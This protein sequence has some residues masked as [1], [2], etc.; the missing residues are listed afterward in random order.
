M[1]KIIEERKKF[2]LTK[3]EKEQ[4]RFIEQLNYL[5]NCI[6]DDV[7]P[8][9]ILDPDVKQIIIANNLAKSK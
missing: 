7:D 5:M 4:R 9:T 3:A 1:N 6:N 2:K 8:E